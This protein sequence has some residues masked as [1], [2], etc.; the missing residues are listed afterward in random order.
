[1]RIKFLLFPALVGFFF[2]CRSVPNDV[3]YLQDFDRYLQ[4]VRSDTLPVYDAIIQSNDQLTILVTSPVLDQT[5]VAQFNLPANTFLATGETSISQ[6]QAIQTYLVDPQ[7]NINFPVIGKIRLAGLTRLQAAELISRKV[8]DYLP[9]PPIVN[10]Q[11]TSFRINVL[12]EVNRPGWVGTRDA[13]M[14]IFEALGAAGDLTIYGD[15]RNV[16]LIRENNG[17]R[18]FHKFDLTSSDIFN[19]P[20]YYLRQNDMLY[21]MPNNI[22]IS[23]SRFGM[24][25]NYRLSVISLSIGTLSFISTVILSIITLSRPQAPIIISPTQQ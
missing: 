25:Q 19:S 12:G 2:S 14:S 24:A 11:I 20:Y 3:S 18:N 5:Q 4:S 15:R 17:V 6:S 13:R 16:L 8:S 7:G 10:L 22:R 1:M 9:D 21:V 23:D